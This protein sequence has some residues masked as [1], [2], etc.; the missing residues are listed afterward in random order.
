MSRH[1]ERVSEIAAQAI[2]GVIILVIFAL[3]TSLVLV[4]SVLLIPH[5]VVKLIKWV[6]DMVL[7]GLS[8]AI[9]WLEG[10]I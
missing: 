10:L 1:I 2:T 6:L 4:M 5:N 9:V 8:A 3:A 7:D